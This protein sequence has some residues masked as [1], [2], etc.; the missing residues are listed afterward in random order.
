VK[1]VANQEYSNPG[2]GALLLDLY[3]PEKKPDHALPLVMWIHGGGWK[4]GS[5][6][7]CPLTWLA[8]EGYAVASIDYRLTYIAQWPAQLDDAR[9]ALHWLRTH[10]DRFQLHPKRFAVSGGSSGGHLASLVGTVP[11]PSNESL[12]SRVSAVIDFY[13]TSDVLTLP[14]N[15]PGPDKTDADL[16]K[17]NAAKLLGGIVRDRPD[18]ARQVSTLHQVSR[19]DP[20]FLILHGDKD[21]QVPVAQSQRLHAR[22]QEV[23]V[24]SELHVLQGAG[25]GGKHFDTPEVR[26][27]I[28]AFLQRSLAE[29]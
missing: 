29:K 18:R 19:D 28:R 1:R 6:E 12:S 4:A 15:V 16:A 9:A 7:N 5:K 27:M 25:H 11:T 24:P 22:L 3:L 26:Q 20:P 17:T 23:G 10:A 13:G 8:A 21:D 2:S 14:P